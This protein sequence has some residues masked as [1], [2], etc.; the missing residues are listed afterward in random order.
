MYCNE[1]LVKLLAPN[2]PHPD[3]FHHYVNLLD[4]LGVGENVEKCLRNFELDFLNE[5]G[6]GVDFEYD[7]RAQEPIVEEQWY[8]FFDEEGFVPIGSKPERGGSFFPGTA[9]LAIN[10][11][12]FTDPQTRLFAKRLVRRMMDYRLGGKPIAARELFRK[13]G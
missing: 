6:Y 5:L 4:Q 12:D 11:R 7:S 13:P 9:L 3:L 10:Q 2:D 8:E 1:L